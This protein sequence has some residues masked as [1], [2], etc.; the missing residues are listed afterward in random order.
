MIGLESDYQDDVRSQQLSMLRRFLSQFDY[1]SVVGG[2]VVDATL[3]IHNNPSSLEMRV[4]GSEKLPLEEELI[5]EEGWFRL[6]PSVL[7]WIALLLYGSGRTESALDIVASVVKFADQLP[8]SAVSLLCQPSLAKLFAEQHREVE[9]LALAERLVEMGCYNEATTLAGVIVYSHRQPFHEQQYRRLIGRMLELPHDAR[10]KAGLHYNMGSTLF[11][12]GELRLAIR[13]YHLAVRAFP[14]YL[15]RPHLMQGLAHVLFHAGRYRMAETLCRRLVASGH[16]CPTDHVLLSKALLYQGRLREAQDALGK[17]PISD[18]RPPIG[19][20]F[21]G[22]LFACIEGELG[23]CDF[24]RDRDLAEE[25]LASFA[26][27]CSEHVESIQAALRADPLNA[28]AWFLRAEVTG[29]SDCDDSSVYSM[30]AAIL[31]ADNAEAWAIAV[32]RMWKSFHDTQ[33]NY[34]DSG[35]EVLAQVLMAALLQG[36][37]LVGDS[38]TE[39]AARPYACHGSDAQEKV[40]QAFTMLVEK[41]EHIFIFEDSDAFYVDEEDGAWLAPE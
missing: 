18:G 15:N 31:L 10:P 41:A 7:L 8:D 25:A 4:V 12:S 11:R 36:R 21:Q 17:C 32:A 1:I 34:D 27:P 19:Y 23:H 9:A 33:D 14:D 26:L 16:C 30:V 40:R 28:K 2:G 39:I 13:H 5:S 35:K 22:W 24:H 37:T 6:W 3:I 20:V 38:F 29:D